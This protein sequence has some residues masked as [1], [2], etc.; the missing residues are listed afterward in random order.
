[1]SLWIAQIFSQFGDRVVFVI[2]VAVLTA[3][4]SVKIGGFHVAAAELTSWLYVAF[5]IPAI[6]FSP[7]AGVYVDR[8][9]NRLVM[10]VSN[11]VRALGVCLVATPYVKVSPTAAFSLA[12]LI[13]VGSQFFAPAES[14]SI[15]RLVKKDHLYAANSLF[16]TTMM[17]AL[18]F[19]FAIGEPIISRT[20]I[21]K[22]PFAVGAAFVVAALFCTQITDNTPSKDKGKDEAWWE[23][24]RV[25]MA[26]IV[27]N[28]P[29]YKAILKITVLFST[30]I[31]L[32]IIAVALT[33]QVLDLDTVKFGYIVAAAGV[34]MG[35]GNFLV[36]H[37]FNRVPPTLL[38]YRGF[39]LLGF[40]MSLLGSLGFMQDYLFPAIGMGGVH[41]HGYLI[42][43]PLII[44]MMI[45][46]SCSFV[47]VPTQ[48]LLQ[49][50][51]PAELRG[52]V[53]GAQNTAM[54]AAS[55]IP[56]VLAGVSADYLPGGVST[57]LLIIGLPTLIVGAIHLQ[58]TKAELSAGQAP[59]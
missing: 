8:L 27:N 40:F 28:P 33:Q 29:V 14:A 4:Q 24:L 47:A 39:V 59:V 41:F 11:M 55:T 5:T 49:A 25:G 36:S 13:S 34:G 45:G 1:M 51:V 31:T 7:I 12:F 2:F 30:V 22:A 3:N 6:V 56:V 10:V 18:G 21:G 52:K 15:P 37:Y 16:F 58:K 32:N 38:A 53:F 42:V 54:S 57:T 35:S 26:Y 44:A 48:S 19:G 9:S 50:A 46:V 23:E 43:V 17:I 20:G